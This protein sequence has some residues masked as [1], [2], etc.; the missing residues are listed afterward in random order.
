MERDF[1]IEDLR[2]LDEINEVENHM[3]L[4]RRVKIYKIRKNP[5]EELQEA[6]F[7]SKYRFSKS[8]AV[9]IIDMVKNNLAGDARGGSIQLQ[10]KKKCITGQ[11][12]IRTRN[13]VERCFGLWK[14]RFRCLLNGFTTT[15]LENIK[16]YLVALAVLH[17]IAINR[18]D[19]Y[20]DVED[21]VPVI[22]D[23]IIV[24]LNLKFPP[25]S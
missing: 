5:L 19:L 3:M 21:E 15:K 24:I 14:Q 1:F 10:R 20:G 6:E 13:V 25:L 4:T 23:I 16:L 22:D 9:F 18:Q 11:A 8:T 17:N 7:K 12:H 2:V